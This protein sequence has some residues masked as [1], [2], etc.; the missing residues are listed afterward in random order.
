M[1]LLSKCR[2]EPAVNSVADSEPSVKDGLHVEEITKK[3]PHQCDKTN[4]IKKITF[5]PDGS[6][7]GGAFSKMLI[8]R[9]PVLRN[10]KFPARLRRIVC[11]PNNP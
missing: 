11:Y 2:I 6:K 3:G 5:I 7:L 4:S 10:R 8:A 1:V 9:A